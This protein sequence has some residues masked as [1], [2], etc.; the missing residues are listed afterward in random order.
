M[1]TYSRLTLLLVCFCYASE[2]AAF[3]N[4]PKGDIGW[5]VPL[6]AMAAKTRTPIVMEQLAYVELGSWCDRLGFLVDL[7]L[8]DN[9]PK[10]LKQA[11]GLVFPTAVITPLAGGGILIQDKKC[12]ALNQQSPL[13]KT[14]SVKSYNGRLSVW[15]ASMRAEHDL[16]IAEY[17]KRIFPIPTA[18]LSADVERGSYP[19]SYAVDPVITVE[20]TN[21]SF[22]NILTQAIRSVSKTSSA[23]LVLQ[24]SDGGDQP[25]ELVVEVFAVG[26]FMRGRAK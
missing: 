22:R 2:L 7:A 4:Q 23:R 3:G 21:G 5:M 14:V 15:L 1:N 10:D 18:G 9:E 16:K 26:E 19:G 11:L 8:A 24:K 13:N 17:P 20:A 6:E 12:I 25:N